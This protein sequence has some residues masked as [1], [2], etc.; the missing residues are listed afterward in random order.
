MQTAVEYTEP[1]NDGDLIA[2]EEWLHAVHHG[3]FIDYDGFGYPVK[4]NLMSKTR[5]YPSIADQLPAD[6]THV[7]WYNR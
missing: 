3:Y 1:L 5:I 6:A 2:R 4:D 7:M